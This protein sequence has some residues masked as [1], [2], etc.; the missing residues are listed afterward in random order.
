[1]YITESASAMIA[2][3]GGK[4]TEEQA[5]EEAI[6]SME[7]FSLEIES[8]D[9]WTLYSSSCRRGKPDVRSS[10]DW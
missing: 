4:L 6:R 2:K 9:W 10:Q 5:K 3:Y 8:V 7:P 1:M